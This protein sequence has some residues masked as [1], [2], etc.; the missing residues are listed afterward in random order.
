MI[1]DTLL[2]LQSGKREEFSHILS[3]YKPLIESQISRLSNTGI[4]EDDLYQEAVIALYSAA[5]SFDIHQDEITFG[6]YA[7]VCIRNRLV[8]YLR[9]YSHTVL[10]TAG[11]IPCECDPEQSF[12]D[13]EN[14]DKLTEFI[15]EQ[16]TDYEK[17]VFNLYMKNESY[18]DISEQLGTNHKSVDNAI[19]RIKR[20]LGNRPL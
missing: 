1:N 13:R 15:D 12:I 18:A 3:E 20:K 19:C 11:E 16:L 7:K 17:S 2:A 4:D 14:Y 6:L 8:S 10:V 9:K 5:C